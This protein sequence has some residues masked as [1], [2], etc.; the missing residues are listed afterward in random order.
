MRAK[1]TPSNQ[2]VWREIRARRIKIDL[3]FDCHVSLITPRLSTLL[4][5]PQN[6]LVLRFYREPVCLFLLFP[7]PLL[8]VRKVGTVCSVLTRLENRIMDALRNVFGKNT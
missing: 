1:C 4:A 2:S 5:E 8:L 7:A 6:Q 3:F